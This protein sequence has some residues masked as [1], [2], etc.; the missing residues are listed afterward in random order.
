MATPEMS[1]QWGKYMSLLANQGFPSSINPDF[2]A[3]TSNLDFGAGTSNPD[4]GADTSSYDAEYY[5]PNMVTVTQG[6]ENIEIHYTAPT[7][8]HLHVSENDTPQEDDMEDPI[9][10]AF[11][12]IS[13][14]A[15]EPDEV[16]YLIPPEAGPNDVDINEMAEVFAQ[17]RMSSSPEPVQPS[18]TTQ[19]T[20]YR[21]APFFDQTF[22]EIPA[23]SID[24]PTMKYAKFYNKNEGRLDVGMLFKNTVDLIESV[25]DHS[26][27]H[28]RREYF[29][30]ESSKTKWKVVCLHST[31]GQVE[32]NPSYGIKHVIQTVKDHTRHKMLIAAAM[33]GNQQVLP[34]AYAIVD[35]EST[36]SWKWF[37]QQL[38]IHVIR[39]R[40]GVCLISDSHPGI[41]KAVREGS[42]FV[43]PHGAHRY[44]LRHVCSNFN[45]RYKNGVEGSLLESWL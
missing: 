1:Q 15:S 43:S 41:T 45:N 17:R 14:V 33:D 2:G 6:L 31:P 35:D 37:L 38:S 20:F 27:R 11:G 21:S 18:R 5:F 8:S 39:G 42:D 32:C 34:L 29:V 36:S 40:W 10:D 30:T 23:D 28:A 9:A 4:F 44:C 3:G 26:I 13:D 24:V 16:D 7:Q 19:Q 25:K 22:P 12:N